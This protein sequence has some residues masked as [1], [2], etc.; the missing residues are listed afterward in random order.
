MAVLGTYAGNVDYPANVALSGTSK[1]DIVTAADD[2]AT[3]ASVSFA[4]DTA[5]AIVCKLYWFKA[6]NAT[7]YL[8]WTS[9]VPA[10]DTETVSDVPIRLRQGDKIKAIGNTGVSVTVIN[11]LNFPFGASR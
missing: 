9:S 3:T 6:S 1:T 8:I 2:Y 5:G 10:N 11:L 4:N 7:D